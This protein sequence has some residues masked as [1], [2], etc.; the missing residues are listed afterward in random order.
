MSESDA[1]RFGSGELFSCMVNTVAV[2]FINFF[3][4]NC[5]EL[6]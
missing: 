6:Y 3:F 5:D 4:I 2:D 1:P